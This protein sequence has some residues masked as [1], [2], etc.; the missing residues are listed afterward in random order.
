MSNRDHSIMALCGEQKREDVFE[1]IICTSERINLIHLRR[2]GWNGIPDR[3]RAPSW[4]LLLHYLPVAKSKRKSTVRRKRNEYHRHITKHYFEFDFCLT[5]RSLPA[6]IR[7]KP[8]RRQSKNGSKK[9]SSEINDRIRLKRFQNHSLAPISQ[10]GDSTMCS[11]KSQKGTV[12]RED[13]LLLQIRN[14]IN[15][16][17]DIPIE[18]QS[19]QKKGSKSAVASLG[20]F[21]TATCTTT[22]R[23]FANA[24]VKSSLERILYLW[25][26]R[27]S[28]S[29]RRSTS[30]SIRYVPG[31]I[32]IV[33]PLYL[34][35][36]QGY[37]WETHSS[38]CNEEEEEDTIEQKCGISLNDNEVLH[39]MLKKLEGDPHFDIKRFFQD[40][41]TQDIET[42]SDV[43][44]NENRN[45]KTAR[46]EELCLG[47][48]LDS[49]SD[50]IFEEIEADT[51]WCLDNLMTAIQDYRYDNVFSSSP[52][53]NNIPSNAKG[54]QSMILLLDEIV[55]RVDPILHAHL[56][57]NGV[58]FL[59]FAFRWMNS[60]LVRDLNDKCILRLWDT[61]LCEEA[62][63]AGNGVNYYSTFGFDSER[64]R[65]KLHLSGFHSFQVYVC[66][67]L[68]H[69]VRESILLKGKFVDIL[70]ELQNLPL[71][72][73]DVNDIS[74]LLSQAFAWKETFRGSERQLLLQSTP[75]Y[76]SDTFSNWIKKCHWPPRM[77]RSRPNSA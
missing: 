76:G 8:R 20:N 16:M 65:K 34:T 11:Q 32:D 21:Q 19:Q 37:V 43:L 74:M 9:S 27:R 15:T 49:F 33:Y 39:G 63:V 48:G 50:E 53:N 38:S 47:K 46:C 6:N 13:S 62:D 31:M 52:S 66:A 60:L 61:Y 36:L 40:T 25:S 73:W 75:Q 45:L 64:V 17:V 58:E 23:S 29:N 26:V 2:L 4:K 1:E 56:K 70:Q 18:S 3:F 5:D 41:N 57:S 71:N 35:F 14:D 42:R 24:R 12:T 59:W 44:G 10:S 55:N 72:S 22:N 69:R 77:L 30:T 7:A 54:L 28:R 67:A 68:L 51:Y